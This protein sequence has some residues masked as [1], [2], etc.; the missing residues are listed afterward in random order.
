MKTMTVYRP[1]TTQSLF[2]R[3]GILRDI[4]RYVES[5][6]EDPFLTPAMRIFN[7]L[8]AVDIRET[9]NAYLFDMD[10]PGHDEKDIEIS[11]D[12]G[13]LS[14]TSKHENAKEEKK[15]SATENN[16]AGEQETIEDKETWVLRER[17]VSSFNRSFKMPDNANPEEVNASFRNGILHLE[18]KK[19]AEARKRTIQINAG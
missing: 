13:R 8:P 11:V 7:R 17:K 10:L 1:G 5:L 16:S 19:R 9:G 18:I 2:A 15:G 3:P 6:F 4:D 12:G 14:I